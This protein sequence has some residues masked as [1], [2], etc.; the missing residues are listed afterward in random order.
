MHWYF[1]LAYSL[2]DAFSANGL[3]HIGNGISEGPF[4]TPFAKPPGKGL[5]SSTA[6]LL[7]GLFN[8]ALADLLM[9][10]VSGVTVLGSADM[11]ALGTGA[12]IMS[13]TLARGFGRSHGGL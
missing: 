6:N 1:Y 11:L 5:P 10:R 12:M 8:F 7:R 9:M 13:G 2:G 4:Q 3:L